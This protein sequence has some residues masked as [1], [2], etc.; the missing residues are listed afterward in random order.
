LADRATRDDR[1]ASAGGP[2]PELVTDAQSQ[3]EALKEQLTEAV[4]TISAQK[5]MIET[6]KMKAVA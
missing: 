6:L 1:F 5:T 3:I 4:A 2:V